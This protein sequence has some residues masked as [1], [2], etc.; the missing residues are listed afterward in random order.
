MTV[1]PTPTGVTNPVQFTYD[2][3]ATNMEVF[4][5]TRETFPIILASFLSSIQLRTGIVGV[6]TILVN[7][8]YLK[9]ELAK[10]LYANEEVQRIKVSYMFTIKYALL[11]GLMFIK[12]HKC[13]LRRGL[14]R[15]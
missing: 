11:Q 10:R 1:I 8:L 12:L 2:P 7:S 4:T 9:V 6:L 5:V 3:S 13:I 15:S 14:L